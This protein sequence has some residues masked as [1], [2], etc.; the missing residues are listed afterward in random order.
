MSPADFWGLTPNEAGLIVER[1]IE[2]QA[3]SPI[4]D[5][6]RSLSNEQY[7]RLEDRRASLRAKGLNVL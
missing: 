7:D 4:K 3:K 5:P 1:H 2:T 6:S